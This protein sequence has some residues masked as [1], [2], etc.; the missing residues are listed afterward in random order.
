MRLYLPM[1]FAASVAASGCFPRL[2]TDK[3]G[4]TGGFDTANPDGDGGAGD[5]GS[6]SDGGAGDGGADTGPVDADGDGYGGDATATT[7][8]EAPGSGYV[9]EGGDCDDADPAYHPGAE[10]SCADPSQL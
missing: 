5:G 9:A 7:A 3:A 10:E 8:C 1:L 2:S 6:A 4:R